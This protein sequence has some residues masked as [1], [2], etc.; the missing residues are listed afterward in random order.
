L[1]IQSNRLQGGPRKVTH[2]TEVLNMEQETI[3]MQDIFLFVQDGIAEDGRAYGH[4]EST[5]VRPHCMDRM[6]AA[7]VRLPSN[8][9]SARVLG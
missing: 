3:I 9:F 1:I 2:I 5:G 8:L 4:F 7:G 6:E